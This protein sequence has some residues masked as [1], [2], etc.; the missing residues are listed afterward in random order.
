M[1][2]STV[3]LF[4]SSKF[5][6]HHHFIAL[7][8]VSALAQL[9]PLSSDS[10]SDSGPQNTTKVVE[11]LNRL[12]KKPIDALSYFDNLKK[13]GFLHDVC[14]YAAIVRILCRF[15]LN[16]ELD[17]I[18]LQIIRKQNNVEFEVI[19]LLKALYHDGSDSFVRVSNAMVK[20]Y[21]VLGMFDQVLEILFLTERHGFV[22]PISSYNF[23]MNQ[24]VHCGKMDTVLAVYQQLGRLGL[25]L[26]VYTYV[27]V[28]KALFQKGC[29]EEAF[30]VYREMDKAEVNPNEFAYSTFIEGLCMNGE[31]DLGH[32]LLRAWAATKIP[33][34]AFAYTVV[35]RG[36][37]NDTRLEEAEGLLLFMETQGVVPDVHVYSALISGYCKFGNISKALALH[38]EMVSKDI[39]TD[40]VVVN[41]ILKCFCQLGRVSEAVHQLKE[42]EEIGIVDNISYNLVVDALCKLGRVDEA[43]VLF[44]EMK[45]N[46]MVLD[47]VNYTTMIYGYCLQGKLCDALILF[48]EMKEKG[49][50]PDLV[51][52]K[53]LAVGFARCDFGQ[54]AIDLLNDMKK[55]GLGPYFARDNMIIEGL[56]LGGKVKEAEAFF[57]SLQ[58]KCLENYSAMFNGYCHADYS[59]KAFQLF[60][61]ISK[62]GFSVSK[63]SIFKLLNS[64]C[65]NGDNS[66]AK[67]FF[68]RI[69]T[70]NLEPSKIMYSKLIGSCCQAGE[71][72]MASGSIQFILRKLSRVDYT[73]TLFATHPPF[74]IDANFGSYDG[75]I[76]SATFHFSFITADAEMLVQSNLDDLLVINDNINICWN[77]GDC[78]EDV[79]EELELHFNVMPR[80]Y[81][82]KDFC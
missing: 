41:L 63:G 77:E 75:V 67:M 43:M 9:K 33:L 65:I 13:E 80:G 42:L 58:E 73:V 12:K 71:M 15:R 51:T 25:S 69:L 50:E 17:L 34:G 40:C 64:L 46:Q 27:I 6:K 68:D 29:L 32:Q 24:L 70:L 37:C 56:C 72:G 28:L 44:S 5:I 54:V 45:D 3:N 79:T 18:F 81:G 52:Y 22:F 8:S 23:F 16:K 57:H 59:E 74:H 55:Q 10:D 38:S 31:L 26:N 7:R 66:K 11:T 30:E 21:V 20:A 47:V 14:T 76:I 82:T 39:K 60:M 1:R 4:S 62:Q 78:R 2:V 19:D 49:H 35:I 53:I 36:F 61:R 48:K